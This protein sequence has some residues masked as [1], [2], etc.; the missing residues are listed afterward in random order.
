MPWN[1]SP[2][3][4]IGPFTKPESDGTFTRSIMMG[5]R[6]RINKMIKKDRML[7]FYHSRLYFLRRKGGISN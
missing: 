7:I 4:F 3:E 6:I 1:N 5:I 2:K